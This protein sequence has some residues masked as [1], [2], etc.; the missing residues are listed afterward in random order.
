MLQ[1]GPGAIFLFTSCTKDG[2]YEVRWRRRGSLA[3]WSCGSSLRPPDLFPLLISSVRLAG[4]Q[5]DGAGGWEQ[6][7][8][9]LRAVPRHTLLL[10]S[11]KG[12]SHVEALPRSPWQCG[13][14]HG[15]RGMRWRIHVAARGERYSYG[16]TAV[17]C[18][19]VWLP[20]LYICRRECQRTDWEE[21]GHR[22]ICKMYKQRF[23]DQTA[24]DAT[25]APLPQE[26]GQVSSKE[27]GEKKEQVGPCP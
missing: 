27:G 10:V 24:A 21:W 12:L 3:S 1:K 23:L 2:R 22:R 19:A 16:L 13:L 9:D 7:V 11:A 15:W 6:E 8:G 20:P 18:L 26:D 5:G 4:L 14:S 17:H 25:T